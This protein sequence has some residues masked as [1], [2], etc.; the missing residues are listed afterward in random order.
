MRSPRVSYRP[1][2]SPSYEASS[3]VNNYAYSGKLLLLNYYLEPYY[4]PIQMVV[5]SPIDDIHEKH[6]SL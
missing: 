5:Y 6:F 1:S 2:A 3:H 4:E